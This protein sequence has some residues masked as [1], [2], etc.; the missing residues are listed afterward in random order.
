MKDCLDFGDARHR[1][2]SQEVQLQYSPNVVWLASVC[3]TF[4]LLAVPLTGSASVGNEGIPILWDTAWI[5][6]LADQTTIDTYLTTRANQGFDGILVGFANW[7]MQ[8]STLGNGQKLFLADRPFSGMLIGDASQP[9]APGFRYLD[10]IAQKAASL[11][12][13]AAFLPMSNGGS[14]TYV[15]FLGDATRAYNYGFYVGSRYRTF[16]NIIWVLGGDVS[17]PSSWPTLASLSAS[18][19]N[20]LRAAGALQKVTFH[21]GMVLTSPPSTG[22]STDW[23]PPDGQ[24]LD[25]NMVQAGGND[26][27]TAVAASYGLGKPIGLGEGLY[28]GMPGWTELFSR[29]QIYNAFL[30]GAAYATYGAIVFNGGPVIGGAC[31]GSYGNLST[32]AATQAVI[33]KNLVISRGWQ[34]YSADETFISSHSGSKT[35][36]IKGASAAMIYLA[37][38]GSSATV[39]MARLNALGNVTVKRFNPADGTTAS[40]GTYPASGTQTFTTGGLADAVILLDASA[41]AYPSSSPAFS[42]YGSLSSTRAPARRHHRRS[43]RQV[44]C[45]VHRRTERN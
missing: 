7:G 37:T 40:I 21:P 4:L 23:F 1:Q 30:S 41:P 38:S 36:M 22:S 27:K 39:N 2:R 8:T 6:P 12:L 9:N 35:A 17:S 33:A 18:F 29:T 28:E 44:R 10:Y 25:F 43:S 16:S 5:L 26:P 45:A 24:W 31:C 3:L 11:G 20:G 42:P 15:F 14:D 32:P 19:K 34:R 13:H